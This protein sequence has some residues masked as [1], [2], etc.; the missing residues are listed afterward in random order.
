MKKCLNCGCTLE[1]K[2]SQLHAW[3]NDY[4]EYCIDEIEKED[5]LDREYYEEQKRRAL[6][7][8]IKPE[9]INEYLQLIEF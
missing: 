3:Y 4:C 5:E 1:P 7:A 9:Y 2:A 8:G 6:N